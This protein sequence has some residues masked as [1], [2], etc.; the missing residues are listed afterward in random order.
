MRGGME[1]GCDGVLPRH[2]TSLPRQDEEGGL[3]CILGVFAALQN[4]LA[5]PEHHRSM[6][7]KDGCKSGLVLTCLEPPEQFAVGQFSRSLWGHNWA[8]NPHGRFSMSI[9]EHTIPSKPVRSMHQ[10]KNG[11]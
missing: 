2:G 3:E 11:R 4:P 6:S 9:G 5:D 8:F 1:P 7:L 10:N